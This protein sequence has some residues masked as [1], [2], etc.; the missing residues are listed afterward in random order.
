[1]QPFYH[2]IPVKE[3]LSDF[4][5]KYEWAKKNP[6]YCKFI[7]QNALEFS[8]KNLKREDAIARYK[9]ILMRLGGAYV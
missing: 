8:K 6:E 3:D 1:M 4:K 9:N 7:S 5:E 2:Y